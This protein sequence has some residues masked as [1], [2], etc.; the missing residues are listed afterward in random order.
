MY[1]LYKNTQNLCRSCGFFFVTAFC[2]FLCNKYDAPLL[3]WFSNQLYLWT[4]SNQ[5]QDHLHI[6][7]FLFIQNPDFRSPMYC[8]GLEYRTCSVFGWL[9]VYSSWSWLYCSHA[10]ACTPESPKSPLC[11]MPLWISWRVVLS[12]EHWPFKNQT[13]ASLGHFP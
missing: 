4:K 11:R 2:L 1:R 5:I 8:G 7:L 13:M 10:T 3:A 9:M 12:T 6:D